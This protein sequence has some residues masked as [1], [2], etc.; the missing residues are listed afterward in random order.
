MACGGFA[1]DRIPSGTNLFRIRLAS[2]DPV[3]FQ[4]RLAGRGVLLSQPQN[5]AF[6]VGVNET[7]NRTSAH[8]LS[9]AFGQSLTG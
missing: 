3:V 8:E 6:L 2:G 1:I 7:L 9:D 5:G 4:T